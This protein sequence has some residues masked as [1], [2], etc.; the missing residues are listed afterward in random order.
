MPCAMPHTPAARQQPETVL[1]AFRADAGLIATV[2]E[3]AA[4]EDR[5]VSAVIRQALRAYVQRKG[6]QRKGEY[7]TPPIKK[8]T[9]RR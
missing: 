8:T 4:A 6:G 1:T 3:I 9:S 5:S 7:A 2:R